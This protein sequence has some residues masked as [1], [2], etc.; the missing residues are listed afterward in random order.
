MWV[1]KCL[2]IQEFKNSI[3]ISTYVSRFVSFLNEEWHNG[4]PRAIIS[5]GEVWRMGIRWH[6]DITQWLLTQHTLTRPYTQHYLIV[7]YTTRNNIHYHTL[8]QYSQYTKHNVVT[9]FQALDATRGDRAGRG[10]PV[11]SSPAKEAK[12]GEESESSGR[13]IF[14][15]R[16]LFYCYVTMPQIPLFSTCL[17]ITSKFG[18]RREKQS[19]CGHLLDYGRFT[20]YSYKLAKA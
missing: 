5:Q 14:K 19:F 15:H 11:R 7:L 17:D 4:K 18:Q 20:F 8:T 13:H 10:C 6:I 12:P 1:S 2:Q 16:K 3:L 9:T